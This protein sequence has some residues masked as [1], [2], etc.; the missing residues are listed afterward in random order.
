MK[1]I[2]QL[3]KYKHL[4]ISAYKNEWCGSG[5][6]SQYWCGSNP[7]RRVFEQFKIIIYPI[8]HPICENRSN[9]NVDVKALKKQMEMVI[10]EKTPINFDVKDH[11]I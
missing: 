7:L 5:L 10:K 2:L 3:W 9:C 4:L 11:I 1:Y 6:R 8:Q